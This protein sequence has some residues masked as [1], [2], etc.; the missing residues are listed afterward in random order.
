MCIQKEMDDEK[1]RLDKAESAPPS[2]EGWVF[3]HPA[4]TSLVYGRRVWQRPSTTGNSGALEH[5][6][7]RAQ[8]TTRDASLDPECDIRGEH[9]PFSLFIRTVDQADGASLPASE[10]LP[11]SGGCLE[12]RC[13]LIDGELQTNQVVLRDASFDLT[14][15]TTDEAIA[16]RYESLFEGYEGPRLEEAEEDVLDGIQTWLAERRIDD[17]FAEF[18]AS[19][20]VW[21]EQME[22]E[23]WLQHLHDY[24]AS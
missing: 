22:Y 18:V 6:F 10:V 21:V 4:G 7:V 3:T 5:H 13:D 24:V 15:D 2:P 14:E 17:I 16:S 9:F 8:L 12:V 11:N 1:L 23:C 20:C 19:Y